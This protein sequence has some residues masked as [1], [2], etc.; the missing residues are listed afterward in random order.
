[1]KRKKNVHGQAALD[2]CRN[3]E[4]VFC[5]PPTGCFN[6]QDLTLV[7]HAR[8]QSAEQ[9]CKVS[10]AREKGEW[11]WRD[12]GGGGVGGG[13]L[14][15]QPTGGLSSGRLHLNAP[16]AQQCFSSTFLSTSSA[17][18]Q[19]TPVHRLIK[20][21]TCFIHTHA[22]THT[23]SFSFFPSLTPLT[24]SRRRCRHVPPGCK[25]TVHA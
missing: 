7:L 22:R 4:I 20:R 6:E 8:A 18:Q 9:R 10:T 24:F 15:K 2:V 12:G 16:S 3:W 19:T 14:L 17:Q 5:D 23:C 1:M 21:K 13:R 25:H 11:R